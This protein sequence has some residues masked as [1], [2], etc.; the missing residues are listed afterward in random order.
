VSTKCFQ[1]AT[2]PNRRKRKFYLICPHITHQSLVDELTPFVKKLQDLYEEKSKDFRKY[3]GIL[4]MIS[5][6]IMI[7]MLIPFVYT[8][9]IR[10]AVITDRDNTAQSITLT[11]TTITHYGNA[12]AAIDLLNKRID[13]SPTIIEQFIA[14]REEN[15]TKV[16]QST[17]DTRLN[18]VTQSP[19]IPLNIEIGFN[20]CNSFPNATEEKIQCEVNTQ[21]QILFNEYDQLIN[22]AIKELKD[23]DNSSQRTIDIH[24][25]EEGAKNLTSQFE[26]TLSENPKFW[27][28]FEE[29]GNFFLEINK[30]VQKFWTNYGSDVDSEIKRLETNLQNFLEYERNLKMKINQLNEQQAEIKKRL[31]EFESPIGKLSIGFDDLITFFPAAILAASLVIFSTLVDS[32]TVRKVYY[33][34]Y[35]ITDHSPV[36]D[37]EDVV[38]IA[39]LWLDPKDKDQNKPIRW[40]VLSLP[41][42]IYFVS[43]GL[44]IFSWS[45]TESSLGG[46]PAYRALA[47]PLYLALG[48]IVTF[49]NLLRIKTAIENSS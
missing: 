33:E 23:I 21:V 36:L 12:K 44:I 40:L 29:K 39:P 4:V 24:G 42:I 46:A 16:V 1:F 5:L 20:S 6:F 32:I 49:V 25:L 15:A 31:Q 30:H 35:P 37:P 13:K 14:A 18:N 43:I 28:I 17:N 10:D 48:I 34:L 19:I 26:K 45:L 8:Q 22:R 7:F 38:I 3:F 2:K 41:S 9:T 47:L 27:K 11:N